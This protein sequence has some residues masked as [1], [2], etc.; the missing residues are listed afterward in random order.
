[1]KNSFSMY[2]QQKLFFESNGVT[3][4]VHFSHL[5]FVMEADKNRKSWEKLH[6]TRSYPQNEPNLL[7]VHW[8]AQCSNLNVNCDNLAPNVLFKTWILHSPYIL[9][10]SFARPRYI[11]LL[12]TLSQRQKNSKSNSNQPMGQYFYIEF[13]DIVADV[14]RITVWL[15]KLYFN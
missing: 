4:I 10:L 2:R 1:M 6:N 13:N 3:A 14:L 11:P 15:L 9:L 8:E 12:P 5:K 7:K